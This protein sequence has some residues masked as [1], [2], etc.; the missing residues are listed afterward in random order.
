MWA[1]PVVKQ[2]D[3]FDWVS[4]YLDGHGLLNPWRRISAVFIVSFAAYPLI[5][6]W[7]PTGPVNPVARAVTMVA[8]GFGIAGA[9]LRWKRWPTRWQSSGWSLVAIAGIAAALFTLSDP[10]VALM[11]ATTFALLGGYIAY[12]HAV[13]YLLVNLAVALACVAVLSYR[14]VAETGD[15]ALAAGSLIVVLGLVVGVPVGMHSLV[16]TLRTDLQ[17][18][19]RDPLTGL[20]NRRSFSNSASELIRVHR[21]TLGSYLVV[22]LIDLD[23]FKRL[24]DTHG[25]AAGDQ[26]LVAV[27]AALR[28]SCRATAV[29]GRAGGEE[30]VVVDIETTPAPVGMAERICAAIAALPF[31]ITASIG[32]SG[33][34]LRTGKLPTAMQ[35]IEDLIRTADAAMYQAKRAGGN[36]VRHYSDEVPAFD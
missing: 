30:F 22:A 13:G 10:Y 4:A 35:L 11:G 9:G 15:V 31:E 32:T 29:I 20:H 18:S 8:A 7:S 24:N 17:G 26:A 25:H 14:L 12:F 3:Q 19:D 1:S 6:L 27:A 16:H 2:P 33:S 21:H 5:M 36:Q 28:Q 23:D 34:P